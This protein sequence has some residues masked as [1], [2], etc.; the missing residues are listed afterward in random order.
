MTLSGPKPYLATIP[1]ADQV[2]LGAADVDWGA[3]DG[4]NFSRVLYTGP[5]IFTLFP[6]YK[7]LLE[8][9]IIAGATVTGFGTFQWVDTLNAA[10]SAY[11]PTGLL[12][13]GALFG[14]HAHALSMYEPLI[15]TAVHVRQTNVGGDLTVSENSNLLITAINL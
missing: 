8:A 14:F 2:I 9:I 7:Y 4:L 13:G 10:L 15:P 3:P 1:V 6:G 11:N 5:G 12:P